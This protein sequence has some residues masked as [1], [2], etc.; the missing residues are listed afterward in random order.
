MDV[1][2]REY[3]PF[4][5]ETELPQQTRVVLASLKSAAADVSIRIGNELMAICRTPVPR[6]T[7]GP[8]QLV[9]LEANTAESVIQGELNDT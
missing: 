1:V 6:V 2:L 5:E 9:V 4:S 7:T 3:P 8:T